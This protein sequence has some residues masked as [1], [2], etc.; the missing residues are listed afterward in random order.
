MEP[1]KKIKFFCDMDGVFA[2][3][4]TGIKHLNLETDDPS[5][6]W[7]KINQKNNF[8]QSLPEMTNA[9]DLWNII[10]PL[11]P[12]MLSG[13]SKSDVVGCEVGKRLWMQEHFNHSDVIV[14]DK[15]L[16]P[17]FLYPG[18]ILLD[19]TQE[20]IDAWNA[21]GGIGIFYDGHPNTVIRNL[22][23]LGITID[24]NQVTYSEEFLNKVS[25]LRKTYKRDGFTGYEIPKEIKNIILNKFFNEFSEKTGN[26]YTFI[27]HHITRRMPALDDYVINANPT[28]NIV[29][30]IQND[31]IGVQ[32]LICEVDGQ[33]RRPDNNF[34]HITMALDNCDDSTQKRGHKP[35]AS[36]SNIALTEFLWSHDIKDLYNISPIEFTA[37]YH[38]FETEKQQKKYKQLQ[39]IRKFR[40]DIIFSDGIHGYKEI[41]EQKDK[42]SEKYYYKSDEGNI[43][44]NPDGPAII[45]IKKDKPAFIKWMKHGKP[46]K[47]LK[48]KNQLNLTSI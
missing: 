37:E 5:E 25:E 47:E 1:I 28:I 39:D 42:K 31:N 12:I 24:N 13:I 4:K 22:N 46:Y 10:L 45:S 30:H 15:E 2:D 34:Y 16:K 21:K 29:G 6:M 32:L 43:M 36:D 40:E 41:L 38:L 14:T 20:N 19:D 48:Q 27:S 17:D 35:K 26:A 7:Y 18:D 44:H 8:W 23:N 3:F 9:K 33:I 11:N